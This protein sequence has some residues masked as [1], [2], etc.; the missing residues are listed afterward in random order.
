MPA[1]P[2]DSPLTPGLLAQ[3]ATI[4]GSEFD[5]ARACVALQNAAQLAGDPLDQLVSAAAEI[6]MNVSPVRLPLAEVVWHAHHDSPVVI[7]SKVEARWV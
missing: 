5:H 1:T 3:L 4:T 6:Y 7:W 2:P